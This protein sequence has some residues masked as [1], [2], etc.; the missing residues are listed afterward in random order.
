MHLGTPGPLAPSAAPELRLVHSLDEYTAC[1][2]L[3]KETWGAHFNEVVP[4]T[5]LKITNRVGG[6][7]A[8]AFLEDRLVAF[9]Y[10]ITGL[11]RGRLVHWSHMLAV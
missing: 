7:V 8:G 11:E 5:I 3:Q 9:V 4:A 6:I 10:G 1:V 2:Q